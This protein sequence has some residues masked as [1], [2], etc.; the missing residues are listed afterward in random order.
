MDD[1]DQQLVCLYCR[2]DKTNNWIQFLVRLI[3]GELVVQFP[4][5]LYIVFLFKLIILNIFNFNC[6]Y[7]ITK[8]IKI[9]KKTK[10]IS[11]NQ[12][13]NIESNQ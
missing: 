13:I 5:T 8:K 11:I 4:V 2:R 7:L 6:K 3:A 9:K 1:A 10:L 12:Q